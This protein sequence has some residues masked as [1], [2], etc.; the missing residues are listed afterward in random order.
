MNKNPKFKREMI[1]WFKSKI[2]WSLIH[3]KLYKAKC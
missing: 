3:L 2:R 1:K